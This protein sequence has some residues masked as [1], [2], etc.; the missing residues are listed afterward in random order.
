[1]KPV[2]KNGRTFKKRAMGALG[3]GS[4]IIMSTVALAATSTGVLVYAG[5]DASL[6]GSK[7]LQWLQPL[8]ALVTLTSL[9]GS[10]PSTRTLVPVANNLGRTSITPAGTGTTGTKAMKLGIN[11]NVVDYYND[12]RPFVNLVAGSGW[13]LQSTSGT[14]AM[15][16]DRMDADLNVVTLNAGE[17]IL[18]TISVP[19]KAY[20]GASV[21]VVCKWQGKGTVRIVGQT[22][23]NLRVTSSSA[24]FTFVPKGTYGATMVISKLDAQTPLRMIDCR[25]ADA[26]PNALF[27]EN[28]LNEVKK[29]NTIRFMKWQ[30]AVE[31]NSAITWAKRAR[32][33]IGLTRGADGIAVETMV[34]LANMTHTNPWFAMPWNADDEYIRNF[35]IYVRDNLDPTLQVYVE[36][37]NEVWN[38]VYPVTKQASQEGLAR[39]LATDAGIAVLKRYAQRT[40]E[41]MDIWTSVF[42]GKS[43]RLVRVAATQNMGWGANQ[44][45]NY[46]NTATKVDALAVAPYFFSNMQPGVV[47]KTGIDKYFSSDVATMID[48]AMTAAADTQKI[49]KQYNLRFITYE[50]G[51]H[52]SSAAD[53]DQL[54]KVQR[55]SR[56][57]TAYTKYLQKWRDQFGDLMVL[58]ADTGPINQYGAWGMRE[59]I[60]Q[61]LNEAPK[62]NAVELFRQSY[63]TK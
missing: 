45:L 20:R 33:N 47:A 2:V 43:N 56:M 55:D 15:P 38:W 39:G 12:G 41:V 4:T 35:A 40:G 17:N 22:V 8:A 34:Q 37:S 9:P 28:F 5:T 51:Q 36:T 63:I 42:A 62:A 27:E 61:P 60:G 46:N 18:R 57:G 25:E 24:T 29:Y 7:T 3:V 30:T 23:A 21:D 54:S 58:F 59:Y 50:A 1:M 49:A 31:D 11:L 10:S 13:Y 48:V 53:L 32:P 14:A 26:D 19:T 6:T 16:A 44:I 52:L